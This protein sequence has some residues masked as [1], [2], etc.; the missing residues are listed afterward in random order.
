MRKYLHINLKHKTI[1]EKE[2]QGEEIVRA[3]RYLIAK[4][5]CENGVA[6]AD[7]LSADNPLI[8]S[9]G[10]FAGTNFSN[11]NRTSIGCK[12]PLTGGIKES[13]AGGTFG[14]A[15]GQL[16]IAGLN[17]YDV[18]ND[19]TVIHIN[20]DGNISFESAGPYLGK[21]NFETA[22]LLHEKYGKKVSIALCGPVGE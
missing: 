19:W 6:T 18:S 14:V 9:A 13:N 21:G 17:L 16:H 12:S 11:A 3:G 22:T 10:P 20:K 7:P 1:E 2:L 5:L 4:T 8:I 15:L